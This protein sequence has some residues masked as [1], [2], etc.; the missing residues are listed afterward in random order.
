MMDKQKVLKEIKSWGIAI[1]IILFLRGF[2][3]QTFHV[4]TGSMK[5]TILIGDFLIV[6]RLKYGIKLPFTDKY[7]IRIREPK[8]GEIIVFRYPLGGKGLFK[9]LNFVKRCIALEG[10]TVYIEHK[11]LFVNNKEVE[12]P[13]ATN[14]DPNEYPP[15]NIEKE[16]FQ[17]LWEERKLSK[18]PYLRDNFGPVVVPE[19]CVFAMGDN[20][21]ESDDSRFWGPVP[22]NNISGSPILIYWSWDPE[23]PFSSFLQKVRWN[24]I[25]NL[26][27]QKYKPN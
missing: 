11:R 7:L 16:L 12:A 19:G 21:D 2:I 23:I 22:I 9:N 6:N 3:V 10:D 5:D 18:Y 20:R 1:G 13:Y 24:R 4:P 27:I 17:K 15:L 14:R 26:I 25:G 8:R